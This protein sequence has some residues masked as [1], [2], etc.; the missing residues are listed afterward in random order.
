[1]KSMWL[2]DGSK[3]IVFLRLFTLGCAVTAALVTLTG[4]L[5]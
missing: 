2:T 1:M 3:E 4:L 5:V